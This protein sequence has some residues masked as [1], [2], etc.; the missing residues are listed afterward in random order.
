MFKLSSIPSKLAVSVILV[1]S[2][3]PPL[4][5]FVYGV[6][7]C[8]TCR[9]AWVKAVWIIQGAIIPVFFTNLLHLPH[10]DKAWS[11][12]LAIAIQI[13]WL[14]GW[15]WLA[16]QSKVWLGISAVLAL[17]LTIWFTYAMTALIRM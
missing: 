6:G 2:Y 4:V 11:V 8:D 14:A 3:L 17:G 15:T 12:A 13:A 5:G 10:L 16:S 7:H 1:V 9:Q